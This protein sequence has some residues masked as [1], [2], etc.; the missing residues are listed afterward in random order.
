MFGLTRQ[1]WDIA[2]GPWQ[3]LSTK[4]KAQVVAG[5]LG[6]ASFFTGGYMLM[7]HWGYGKITSTLT[8]YGVLC[9][10]E[11]AAAKYFWNKWFDAEELDAVIQEAMANLELHTEELVNYERSVRPGLTMQE[12]VAMKRDS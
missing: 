5:L 1:E 10:V 3:A 6:Q 9:A 2:L 12:R 4:Q 8:S 7:R 11:L